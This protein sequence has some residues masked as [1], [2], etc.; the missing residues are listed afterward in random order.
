M[1]R[2]ALLVKLAF[3][4]WWFAIRRRLMQILRLP[5]NWVHS[6]LIAHWL[7]AYH[8]V[9]Y[10]GHMEGSSSFPFHTPN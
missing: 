7:Q 6:G 3:A 9:H 10:T 8:L 4:W 1:D 5:F 2:I